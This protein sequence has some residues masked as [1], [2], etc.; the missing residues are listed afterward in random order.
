MRNKVCGP[1]EKCE[2]ERENCGPENISKLQKNQHFPYISLSHFISLGN[3][4]DSE[5]GY[6]IVVTLKINLQL[7]I[8][9]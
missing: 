8:L 1:Q 5:I 2:M 7:K 4:T 9:I 6:R 3:Q